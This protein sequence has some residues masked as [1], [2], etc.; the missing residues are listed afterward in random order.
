MPSFNHEKFVKD[1]LT[2]LATQTYKN[3]RIVNCDDCSTDNTF[4]KTKSLCDNLEKMPVEAEEPAELLQGKFLGIPIILA[5][6]KENHGPSAARN[7]AIKCGWA[8][9]DYFALL[10]S[11]DWYEPT[12]IEKSLHYFQKY[13]NIVGCVYS[14]YT[15]VNVQTGLTCRVFGY[16]YSREI[17]NNQCIINCDSLV[18]KAAIEKCGLFPENMRVAED[19]MFWSNILRHYI[20]C[21]IPESLINIRV[22]RHS[23]TDTVSK[24]TWEQSVYAVK[25]NM[26]N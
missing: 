9:T 17:F 12:K 13:P 5:R 25:Q 7:F 23:S 21:H 24:E 19:Y 6:F 8:G 4:E 14:D 16:P 20:A 3:L 1:S 11:D 2:S 22:G 18:S 26:L 15:T 10:D